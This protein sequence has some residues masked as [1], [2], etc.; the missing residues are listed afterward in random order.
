MLT[1]QA[2]KA[3]SIALFRRG[4]ALDAEHPQGIVETSEGYY[5]IRL[6]RHEASER[7]FESVKAEIIER[8]RKNYQATQMADYQARFKTGSTA[9]INQELLKDQALPQ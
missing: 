1:L 2:G 7:D 6:L 5:L 9:V 8:L 4:S 3:E